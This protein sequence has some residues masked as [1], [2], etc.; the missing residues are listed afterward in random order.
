MKSLPAHPRTAWTTIAD[1]GTHTLIPQ[2]RGRY[3]VAFTE[4]HS[5]SSEPSNDTRGPQHA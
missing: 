1:P 3:K 2:H 5:F 4:V